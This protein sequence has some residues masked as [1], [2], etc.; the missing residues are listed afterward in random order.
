[1]QQIPDIEIEPVFKGDNNTHA[2]VK[3][4]FFLSGLMSYAILKRLK[5]SGS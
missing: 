5:I 1:L 2:R 4:A 3:L